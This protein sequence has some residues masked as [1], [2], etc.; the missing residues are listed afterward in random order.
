MAM[1]KEYLPIDYLCIDIANSFGDDEAVGFKGD[2]DLFEARIQ[3]VKNNFNQLEERAE[4]ADEKYLY[5]KGV[6]ALR[7]AM[8]GK[9][10]GHMV[11]LDASCSGLQIMS[12]LTGCIRGGRI[13]GQIDPDI[14]YDAYTEI[15]AQMNTQLTALSLAMIVIKRADAKQAVMTSVYGSRE[16]PLKIFGLELIDQYYDA[17]HIKAPGAFQLLDVLINAWQPNVLLNSWELPDGH[18]SYVKVMKK[19][20]TEIEIDELDHHK[21]TTR[22]KINKSADRGVSLAANVTHSIDS[23]LLRSVLRR[24]NYSIKRIDRAISLITEEL[25]KTNRTKINSNDRMH[26]ADREE[27]FNYT[28]M[29]DASTLDCINIHTIGYLS[30]FHMQRLLALAVTMKEHKPFEILTVHD[31][32]RTHP[33]NCNRL[34]YWYKELLAEL[35]ESNILSDILTQITGNEFK[36]K[37]LSN[38]MAKFIRNSN[39]T[40]G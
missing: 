26:M 19:V 5:I 16:E 7:D 6:M 40:L 20:E 13:T 39:Y 10:T 29:V 38:T 3:W 30:A 32:F 21:F 28:N 23:Y 11:M 24:T 34:R 4:E 8:Q 18:V 27:R 31:A 1:F 14:R 33:N 15:T 25:N 35:N 9:E 36:Y 2:K 17:C 37:K 22:Y 12:A